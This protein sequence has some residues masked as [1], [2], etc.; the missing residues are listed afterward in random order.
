MRVKSQYNL[1]PNPLRT[2][3]INIGVWDMV[4][5]AG[6]NVAHGLTAANIGTVIVRISNDAG[7]TFFG[8]TYS[9]AYTEVEGQVYWDATDIKMSRRT[10]GGF[11][12]VSYNDGVMNRGNI[13]IGYV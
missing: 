10:G 9:V 3:V 6:V 5:T 1:G 12:S 11:D 2:K 7:D 8:L 13:T 4:A